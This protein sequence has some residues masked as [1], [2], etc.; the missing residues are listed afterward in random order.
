MTRAINMHGRWSLPVLAALLLW[1]PP[2]AWA[3][4]RAWLD[5]DRIAMGDTVTLNVESDQ[6]APDF[7]PL[8]TDFDLSGQTSSRQ[9]EWSNGS[10]QQRNL[11][12]VALTPRRS[13]ALVVPGLQVGSVRTAPL[14]LQVDAA[15]V[16]GPDSNAMAFI[17][18]VVDDDTPYVQQSVGVV[19]RLYFASQLASGELVL[20][21]PAGASLQRVGDDRTDVRQVNG[22][23]YNVVER[24][25]LLIPERSGALRL[26]GARFSGRSAGGFFDDFFGGGDGR[27]NATGADRTLQVQAQPAQAPQPWLPLQSL[28][29]RYTSAPT[30]ARTGEAANVV[31]E[32]VAEGATRAQFTDLPVPDVGNAAQVFAEPAQYEETFNGSTPRL[33]ITRRYSI[34]PRQP[35]SLVVPGPR[36]PWWDVRNGKAQEAKLPDLTLAVAAGTGAATASPAAL[37]PID[38]AA[39]LPGSD[40]QDARIAATDPRASGLSERPWPWMAAAIG[41]ALLWLLTLLWGWQRGRH[42]RAAAPAA[43]KPSVTTVVS[44]RAGLAELRRAL[45][46]EGFDQ[47][48]A[49]LCAMAGVE[50]IEQVIARLDDPAQRQVLLDLQQARWGG[51]GE[52]APLRTRLR[53]VF[54]DG[55]HWSAATGAAETGLAPLY[56]PRR[57]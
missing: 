51:Q 53:E 42:P 57:T 3:Q 43:G 47:V 41:L 55:P 38:T 24:R 5:R 49:R 40:G 33:K 56:P 19:V 8:R 9:V 21:T 34:V 4:P 12:G 44:G 15:A 18:T 32:A 22:R 6:G 10:M 2:L 48:E 13:G 29:L 20:D 14:T 11:Y 37:P 45:D 39:A 7:T 27:M 50:R 54:R 30:R 17:E 52:L 16:A 46:G 1:L 23:R 25:F 26:S 31:V 28:Q 36:L 35:G